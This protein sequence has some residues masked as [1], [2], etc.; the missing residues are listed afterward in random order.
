MHPTCCGKELHDG[1]H[2]AII[3]MRIW[4][5]VQ[6]QLKAAAQRSGATTS[7][8]PPLTGKLFAD[9]ERLTPTHSKKGGRRYRYYI[10][11]HTDA[12]EAAGK[13]RWRVPADMLETAIA[14]ALDDWLRSPESSRDILK[15]GARAVEHQ[16]LRQLLDRLLESQSGLAPRE[17]VFSWSRRPARIDLDPSGV[18]ILLAPEKLF[19]DA[20][21]LTLVESINVRSRIN[22]G[23]RGQGLR[24]VLGKTQQ[25]TEP[26]AALR[27]LLARAHDWRERWFSAPEKT[28]AEIVCDST[29]SKAEI[30]REMRL[31]F[32]APDIV[33]AVLNGDLSLTAKQLRR[34]NDLPPSWAEQR[35]LFGVAAPQE[36]R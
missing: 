21:R 19:E 25:R 30:S 10:T 13:S 8:R 36:R 32:L 14:K 22:I 28:L 24:L 9:G 4:E 31:A 33:T 34:L 17:R 2:D 20:E 27:T 29:I 18:S 16:R 3:D 35:R 7:A 26:K 11:R 5:A 6:A 15:D 23:P 1:A 12:G